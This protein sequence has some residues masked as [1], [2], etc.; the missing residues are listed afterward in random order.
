MSSRFNGRATIRWL[1][2]LVLLILLL[3]LPW[4]APYLGGTLDLLTRILIWGLMGL[5]FDLLFGYT[6]LLSFGQSAFYGTGGFVTAYLLTGH[7]LGSVWLAL[8]IGTVFA[9]LVGMLVGYL[10]LR[11]VGIYFAMITLAFGQMAYFLE[12]SPLAHWTGGENGLPG[13]PSPSLTL[14][15]LH[16][17]LSSGLSM[18]ALI[19]VLFF[20]GFLFARRV[21]A[22]PVGAV[23]LAIRD[24]TKRAAA[25]GHAV[26]RYKLAVFV[27]AS[28]YAGLA[29]GLLGI[30]Q[31]YMP[32]DSFSLGTSGQLV[33]QS[34]MGGVG[35]LIG[36]TV[37]A[38][39]WLYLRNAFQA[40]PVVGD[41][42]KF[43]LGLVFVVLVTAFRLGIAG[44]VRQYLGGR[45]RRGEAAAKPAEGGEHITGDAAAVELVMT[46]P[47]PLKPEA[48]ALEA[49][50]LSRRFGGLLAVDQVSLQV[51][52]GSLHAVIGPNGAGKSTLFKM[53]AGEEVPTGGEFYMHGQRLTGLGVERICQLGLSKSYQINQLFPRLTVRQNLRIA[54]LARRRGPFRLDMLRR[55]DSLDEVEE[56]IERIMQKASLRA[57]A[58]APVGVLAY[59]E[60]R[61]LEIGLAL[62]S[63]PN[64]LLLDEPLAG[65]SPAERSET[66]DWIRELREGRTLLIV[67][68]DMDAIFELADRITVLSNGAKLAEGTPEEIQR[69]EE[70]QNSYLGGLHANEPA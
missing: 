2:E 20:L 17:T 56:Q 68:H 25:L 44:T 35:T 6:G 12:N 41:L 52:T 48:V 51:A 26:S 8:L 58:D 64:V 37:G 59:G 32:P 38:T 15:G 63:G 14:G 66:K 39:V 19:G 54:A 4:I 60:K 13:I 29:G 22:S 5:G 33:V 10:A 61:R 9:A 55:A 43:L 50:E 7:V 70:V 47:P 28:L 40:L 31:S 30:F 11:R 57:R 69:H 27:L 49:H 62:T 65:M 1:P 21:V 53:L 36:P 3:V 18:Y 46:A 23:M 42:W 24:N 16:V 67:E 45:A 34:V